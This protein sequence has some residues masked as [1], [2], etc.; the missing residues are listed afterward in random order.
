[1]PSPGGPCVSQL[2]AAAHLQAS[3]GQLHSRT[4]PL[5]AVSTCRVSVTVSHRAVW[6]WPAVIEALG[7]PFLHWKKKKGRL[8]F[9]WEFSRGVWQREVWG[10]SSPLDSEVALGRGSFQDAC[11]RLA[12]DHGHLGWF[13]TCTYFQNIPSHVGIG[14][15]VV[16][17]ACDHYCILLVNLT[18]LTNGGFASAIT[19][20]IFKELGMSPYQSTETVSF[21][22]VSWTQ[23][24]TWPADSQRGRRLI[25]L[26]LI[27]SVPGYSVCVNVRSLEV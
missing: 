7:G 24:R 2:E 11:A 13:A 22:P 10:Y 1:M 18:T 23:L 17:R 26:I 19:R 4:P 21:L 9:T 16:L 8:F 3:P 14:L 25:T 20:V 5:G 12:L 6:I 27:S 15:N